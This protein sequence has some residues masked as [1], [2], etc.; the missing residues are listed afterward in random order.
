M[1]KR[2]KFIFVSFILSVLLWAV[3]FLVPEHRVQAIIVMSFLSYFVSAWVL[4]EDLK[5]VEWI[6]IMVLP[7]M[8]TLGA[9]L[10]SLFLP[11]SIPVIMGKQLEVDMARL[12]AGVIKSLYWVGFGLGFYALYLTENIFSVAAIRTIQLLRAAHAVGFLLT[13]IVSFFLFHALFSFRLPFYWLSILAGLVSWPLLLQGCWSMQL[14]DGINKKVMAYTSIGAL[15]IAQV[16]LGLSF[17]PARVLTI[18]LGL[19]SSLYVILGLSQHA[20]GQ[21]LFRNQI[22]EYS[23]IA[24]VVFLASF[25]I[26]SWR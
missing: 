4:F 24:M 11:E 9:G 3:Q 21:R 20:I 19:V 18:T 6:T 22:I 15:I 7:V 13:L 8:Y 23:A 1:T 14:K 25:Y 5:G 12:T 10:F 16:A 2:G 26:T 17:W